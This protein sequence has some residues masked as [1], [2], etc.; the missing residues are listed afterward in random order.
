MQKNQKKIL[1]QKLLLYLLPFFE[2]LQLESVIFYSQLIEEYK[3]KLKNSI[4]NAQKTV[5]DRATIFAPIFF[6][7]FS[8]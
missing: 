1:A 7:D 8:A 4:T 6:S 3:K 5:K 2:H